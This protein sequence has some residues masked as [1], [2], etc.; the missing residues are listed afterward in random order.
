MLGI[1]LYQHPLLLAWPVLLLIDGRGQ[2]VRDSPAT[3]VFWLVEIACKLY[4][5]AKARAANDRDIKDARSRGDARR[6]KVLE[7]ER[8]LLSLDLVSHVT[9]ARD[10]TYVVTVRQLLRLWTTWAWP[11]GTFTPLRQGTRVGP[12]LVPHS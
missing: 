4:F 2:L 3:Q 9:K 8:A 10:T 6:V 5:L 7:A 11:R 12:G 1:R